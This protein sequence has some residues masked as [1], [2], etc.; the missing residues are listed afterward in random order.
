MKLWAR[1]GIVVG[2]CSLI[3]LGVILAGNGDVSDMR[4]AEACTDG[5]FSIN[6]PKG[7]VCHHRPQYGN[8]WVGDGSDRRRFVEVD[9]AVSFSDPH[10]PGFDLRVERSL[11]HLNS[12][13]DS[14]SRRTKRRVYQWLSFGNNRM[15][16]EKPFTENGV[17]VL[18]GYL[19]VQSSYTLCRAVVPANDARDSFQKLDTILTSVRLTRE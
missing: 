8:V 19:V 7:F 2:V 17:T 9:N 13:L 18:S 12:R 3:V 15:F 16:A 14:K 5:V 10:N 6:V 4:E 1:G 11:R